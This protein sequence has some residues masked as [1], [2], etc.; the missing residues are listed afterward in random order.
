MHRG[1]RGQ[2]GETGRAGNEFSAFGTIDVREKSRR[3]G[4]FG[5]E[6]RGEEGGDDDDD[7]GSGRER[8]TETGSVRLREQRCLV[9][10]AAR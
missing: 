4:C 9:F 2:P 1:V 5:V 7:G 8:T 6:R 3:G 10:H